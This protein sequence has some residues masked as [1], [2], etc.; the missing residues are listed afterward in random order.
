MAFFENIKVNW[1]HTKYVSTW[2][3]IVFKYNPNYGP[4]RNENLFTHLYTVYG[5]VGVRIS[6]FSG[7][8]IIK[9]RTHKEKNRHSK[10]NTILTG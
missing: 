7:S 5:W 3:R 9:N 10:A 2:N 8:T 1:R 4:Y 6:N